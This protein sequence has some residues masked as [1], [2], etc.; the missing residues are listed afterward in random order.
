METRI[1]LFLRRKNEYLVNISKNI[2][3][4]KTF[5]YGSIVLFENK[6]KFPIREK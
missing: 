4:I 3:N 6:M 1:L 2:I 5:D